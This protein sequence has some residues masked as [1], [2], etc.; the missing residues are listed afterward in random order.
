ML[1]EPWTHPHIRFHWL[2]IPWSSRGYLGEGLNKLRCLLKELDFHNKKALAVLTLEN[3]ET[4]FN[5][6]GQFP[7]ATHLSVFIA[8]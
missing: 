4:Q 8:S 5:M 7:V 6:Y 1:L 2:F 3:I